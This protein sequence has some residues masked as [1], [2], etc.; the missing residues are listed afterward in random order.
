MICSY[1][2]DECVWVGP[3][4]NLTHTECRGCGATNAQVAEELDADE[5]AESE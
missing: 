2:G 5:V 1:C 3:W 4:S